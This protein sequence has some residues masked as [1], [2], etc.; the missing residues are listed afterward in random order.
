VSQ[1]C[2]LF[3]SH[4]YFSF[5]NAGRIFDSDGLQGIAEVES[6]DE[7]S[8]ILLKFARQRRQ[9]IKGPCQFIYSLIV[10]PKIVTLS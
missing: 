2:R 4:A 10:G 5:V 9:K 3:A 8:I 6:V 1:L 7:K